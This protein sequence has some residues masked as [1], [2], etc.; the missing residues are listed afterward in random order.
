M[1]EEPNAPKISER[2]I[3][4]LAA[5][6]GLVGGTL[7]AFIGG[8]VANEGQEQRFENERIAEIRDLRIDAYTDLLQ[9][10]ESAY[11]I[12]GG[13]A[14][15]TDI[16]VNER[17]ADLTAAQARA[18]LVTSST[19]VRETARELGPDAGGCGAVSPSDHIA[20]EES[21][22]EAAQPEVTSD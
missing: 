21:F 20:A 14:R 4:L 11:L 10:C 16:E 22:I 17:V 8:W 1:A 18:S 7:G 5:V 6:I 13:E 12:P 9:A 2:W 3:P 15:P 19:E